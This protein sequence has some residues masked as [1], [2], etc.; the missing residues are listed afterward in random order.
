MLKD[1]S[2][3]VNQ[4]KT[5]DLFAIPFS[6]QG[7]HPVPVKRFPINQGSD[8]SLVQRQERPRT[9]GRAHS[10]HLLLQRPNA[11]HEERERRQ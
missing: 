4:N 5:F 1:D 10:G 11:D 8:P 3:N 9:S 6:V 7:Q 2:S